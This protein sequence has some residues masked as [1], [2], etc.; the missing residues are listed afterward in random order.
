MKQLL[1]F[2]RQKEAPP[3]STSLSDRWPPC[4]LHP[5]SSCC[6][7]RLHSWLGSFGPVPSS[8][9][10]TWCC[11]WS[12]SIHPCWWIDHPKVYADLNWCQNTYLNISCLAKMRFFPSIEF[13]MMNVE[14]ETLFS[15]VL[16]MI[17]VYTMVLWKVFAF[18]LTMVYRWYR[19]YPPWNEQQTHLKM[20][21]VGIRSF[22]L[23]TA[24]CSGAM[25]SC[26]R[27]FNEGQ[28]K[29]FW[30]QESL[31][32]AVL[33]NT[34]LR[35]HPKISIKVCLFVCLFVRSFV[36]LFV[37]L[38]IRDIWKARVALHHAMSRSAVWQ[39]WLTQA[40]RHLQDFESE[41]LAVFSCSPK[42]TWLQFAL[43]FP[44]QHQLTPSYSPKGLSDVYWVARKMGCF[45]NK[46]QN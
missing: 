4:Y 16:W 40:E 25:F 26:N 38:N 37:C 15:D 30:R 20:E 9:V 1:G 21:E 10:K 28:V 41:E 44:I 29:T 19:K 35:T 2:W 8:L 45:R 27:G 14:Y 5:S 12:H 18:T 31:A 33:K 17:M 7:L 11:V 34:N 42:H 32:D 43:F 24:L 13:Q 3:G 23:E 6:I 36:C 22:P 39:A 46:Q